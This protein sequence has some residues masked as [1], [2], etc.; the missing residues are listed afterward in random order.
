ML[1]I[2]VKKEILETVLDLRFVVASLLC[3]VFFPLGM[4]VNR[5]DYEQRLSTYHQEHQAYRDRYSD[6]TAIDVE[7]QGFRPPAVMSVF[8]AGLDAFVPD[9]VTTSRSGV[10]SATKETGTTNPLSLLFGWSISS[11]TPH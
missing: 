3:L 7:V 6:K 4:Y 9:R 8:V 2:L 1:W 10:F 5:V 11:S